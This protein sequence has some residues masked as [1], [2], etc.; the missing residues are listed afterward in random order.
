[1]PNGIAIR[2]R[3][4]PPRTPSLP[5]YRKVSFFVF[6]VPSSRPQI[7]TMDRQDATNTEQQGR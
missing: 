5:L 1:M 7:T 4:W 3:W 6:L 2:R